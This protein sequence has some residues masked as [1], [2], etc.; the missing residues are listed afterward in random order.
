M[1]GISD[2]FSKRQRQLRGEV[3]DVYQYK[4]LPPAFRVQVVH[5]LGDLFGDP[6]AYNS[7]TEEAFKAIHQTL[8]REYGQ[9]R[10]SEAGNGFRA[11]VFHFFLTT[12]E[13]E[14]ALDVIELAFRLGTH[15]GADQGFC[16]YS[17]P[18]VTPEGA[19]AELNH[20]FREHGIGFQ[21][22]SD[23]IV[24]VDSQVLHAEAVKPALAL[25]LESRFKGANSEFLAAHE[26]HRHGRN[27]EC[28]VE[29]LKALESTLK[30][31]A[32]KQGWPL[33]DTDTVKTLIEVVFAKGLIPGW[34]QSEFTALRTTLE[35]GVPTARNR[36]A[37]HGQG[38][39]PRVI[40]GHIAAY[41]LHLTASSIVFLAGAEK[42]LRER[43]A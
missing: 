24:R 34:L 23:K 41:V 18:T 6:Q 22:E 11:E 28:I 13:T 26:H 29:C 9:F 3:P 35:S 39:E 4:T 42:N 10:L 25:L 15:L 43:T 32:K 8:C 27:A 2:L 31:I 19:T 7:Q 12:P 40:P 30:I 16:S 14:K 21:Y 5:I 36:L 37:G 38:S 1:M 17:K 20:R 33:K